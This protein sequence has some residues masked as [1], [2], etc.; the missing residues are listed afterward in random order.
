MPRLYFIVPH[1]K[2]RSPSQRYRIEQLLGLFE[3]LGYETVYA[4]LLDARDDRIFYSK[5]RWLGKL[6]ILLRAA[7]RRWRD[8][9]NVRPDDI[10]FIHRE[11]FMT[12]GTFFE[13]A[14][15]RRCRSMVFD[16]DDAIW[17]MDVSPGNRRLRWLK[18]PA[19]TARIVAMADV[20][21]AGND[22][23]ADFARQH[24]PRVEVIP[25]VVDT[26]A[27]VSQRGNS[28][29]GPVTVGWTGSHTSMTH[30]REAL[31][32]LRQVKSQLG[33]RVR[34]RIISDVPL[35]D[36][37]LGAEHVPWNSATEAQDL[38]AID[39]GIMPMPDDDWSRGKCGF[40]GLQYMAMG[41][42]V[43]L[44]DVGVNG[45]IVQHGVNGFLARKPE[46][47]HELIGRLVDDAYLRQRSGAAARRS[48]EDH[49][50][51]HAVAPRYARILQQLLP[52]GRHQ[53]RPPAHSAHPRS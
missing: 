23:L 11:A 22:Y 45:R 31:P 43:V 10:V 41:K 36:E 1:R 26:D 7:R 5:G 44:S 35:D 46:D 13:R 2:D 6:G 34:F 18:D 15:R 32:M 9:R 3:G 25:T 47:W 27:Y 8:V 20:V 12:R 39:I 38:D 53:H 40:K 51:I 16:F 24:N 28:P 4:N 50:S 19:K 37:G 30:L 42:A 48:V 52:H 33:E 49:W 17:R 14:L 29:R 21:I